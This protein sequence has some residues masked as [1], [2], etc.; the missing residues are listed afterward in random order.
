MVDRLNSWPVGQRRKGGHEGW[1]AG[2][3]GED[4]AKVQ[5]GAGLLCKGAKV[6][7]SVSGGRWQPRVAGGG[8]RMGKLCKGATAAEPRAKVQR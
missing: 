7:A 1:R 8:V 3:S 6:E 4:S 2:E 5:I